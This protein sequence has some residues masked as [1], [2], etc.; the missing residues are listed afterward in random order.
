MPACLRAE[1]WKRLSETQNFPLWHHI[2][3]APF[4]SDLE[5]AVIDSSGVYAFGWPCGRI[6]GGWCK[7]RRRIGVKPTHWREW[8]V[9]D[10][11]SGPTHFS[12]NASLPMHRV[13]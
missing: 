13:R 2:S 12:R 3:V 7:T 5:L 1:P 8:V 10:H 11:H 4:D 9:E 6:L